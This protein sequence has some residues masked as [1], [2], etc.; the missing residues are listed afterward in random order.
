M[1]IRFE[2]PKSSSPNLTEIIENVAKRANIIKRA[3]KKGL[4]LELCLRDSGSFR[5]Y[6]VLGYYVGLENMESSELSTDGWFNYKAVDIPHIMIVSATNP[7]PISDCEDVEK[8]RAIY[9]TYSYTAL[10]PLNRVRSIR[11]LKYTSRED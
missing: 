9:R 2:K 10:I 4:P 8:D 6:K 1:F 7:V 5:D 3:I 11:T